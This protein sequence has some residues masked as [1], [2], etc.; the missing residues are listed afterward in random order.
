MLPLVYDELRTIADRELRHERPNHT[1]EPTA[2]VHEAYLRLI[3]Q[4]NVDFEHRPHVIG[5]AAQLMRRIL[6][7]HARGHQ[8]VKRRPEM[9]RTTLAKA[10]DDGDDKSVDLAALDDALSR[11]AEFDEQQCRIVELRYF[12]GLTIEQSAEVLG[13]SPATVKREWT[14]AKAWLRREMSPD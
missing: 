8:A 7:D 10:I 9:R 3:R 5:V 6:V 14:L 2:L 1:L 11:L 12:G 4:R 13:I